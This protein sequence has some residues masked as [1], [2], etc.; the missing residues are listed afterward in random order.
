MFWFLALDWGYATTDSTLA[1]TLYSAS[2]T[3]CERFMHNFDDTKSAAQRFQGGRLH[4]VETEVVAVHQPSNAEFAVDVTFDLDASKRIDPQGKI[5]SAAGAR[6]GLI[7]R[8][9]LTWR[10][11]GWSI[12]DFKRG[13]K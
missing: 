3:D 9:W 5:L 2:C 1:K 10:D 13:I 7:Y 4:I 6:R 12:V 11:Q 8:V